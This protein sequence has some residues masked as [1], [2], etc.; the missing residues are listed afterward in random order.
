MLYLIIILLGAIAS[1]IGPWWSIALVAFF[2]CAFIA[3]TP[4]QAFR[5]SAAAGGTLWVGYSLILIYSGKENLVDKIA[6]IFAGS[7]AFLGSIPGL[8]LI[9]FIV[10]LVATL[11]TGF[12]GMA[13]RQIRN[14]F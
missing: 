7:S 10:T 2:V 6:G 11:S 1:L 4:G 13:G 12:A 9:L 14:L 5:I 3:K 8:A